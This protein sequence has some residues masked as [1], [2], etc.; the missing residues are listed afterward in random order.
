MV[1]YCAYSSGQATHLKPA[2]ASAMTSSATKIH[3]D[4]D[5]SD[6]VDVKNGLTYIDWTPDTRDTE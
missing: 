2:V 5:S 1:M 3:D 4:L 6:S